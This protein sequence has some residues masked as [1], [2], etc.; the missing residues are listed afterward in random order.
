MDQWVKI[1]RGR[2]NKWEDR[3]GLTLFS[4]SAESPTSCQKSAT[5]V[6]KLTIWVKFCLGKLFILAIYLCYGLAG[7]LTRYYPFSLFW[8]NCSFHADHLRANR[9]FREVEGIMNE[10]GLSPVFLHGDENDQYDCCSG[11]LLKTAGKRQQQLRRAREQLSKREPPAFL[12]WHGNKF[13]AVIPRNA[14][15]S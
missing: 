11:V 6:G 12:N 14:S 8:Q 4:W 10:A 5:D 7:W 15:D 1:V 9:V 2:S 13:S 3:V